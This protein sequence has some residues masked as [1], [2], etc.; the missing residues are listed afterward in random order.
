M[1]LALAD[2]PIDD[3]LRDKLLRAFAATADHMRNQPEYTVEPALQV[4]PG[5]SS[6]GGVNEG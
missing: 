3:A 5:G 2:T 4:V 6:R 1:Q